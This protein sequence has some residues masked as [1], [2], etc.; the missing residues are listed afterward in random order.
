[1]RHLQ[2]ARQWRQPIRRTAHGAG[3]CRVLRSTSSVQAFLAWMLL[4]LLLAAAQA[5]PLAN[6]TTLPA[7]AAAVTSLLRGLTPYEGSILASWGQTDPDPC[8]AWAG[9]ICSCDDLPTRAMASA[10]QA[11]FNSSSGAGQLRVLG[12]DLGPIANAGGQ[13]LSGTIDSALG[14][15]QE[16]MYLDMSNNELT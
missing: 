8:A 11:A 9:V 2:R 14:D 3:E 6:A 16:L 5:Q 4:L 10:C 12:L 7:D 13:R 15:L 1:M